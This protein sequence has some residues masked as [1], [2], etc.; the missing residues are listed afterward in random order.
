MCIRDRHGPGEVTFVEDVWA[1]GGNLGPSI[2]YF[3]G[4]LE[5]GNMVF[6]K[7]KVGDNGE[8]VDLPIKVI[9]VG[10]GLERIPWLMNGGVTSYKYTFGAA[11][12]FLKEKFKV[13]G[14]QE[15]WRQF[16]KYSCRLDVDEEANIAKAWNEIASKMGKTQE[17]L[18]SSISPAKD[19]YICLDLSLIHIC[20]CRRYAVCR[21]RWSPYH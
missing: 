10:I 3:I 13:D 8:L 7:Y 17:E 4:G 12:D 1:G 14:D 15:V 21:S 20:R 11:Y 6:M 5:V 2:E 19:L 9:D 18:K 16:A